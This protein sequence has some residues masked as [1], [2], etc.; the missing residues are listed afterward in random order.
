[1]RFGA[2]KSDDPV[3]NL[4]ALEEFVARFVVFPFDRAAAREYGRLRAHLHRSGDPIGGNDLM[5]ASIALASGLI[6]ITHNVGEFSKVPD[7]VVEDWEV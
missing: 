1:M 6:L 3:R 7:L 2:E 4:A 5:I